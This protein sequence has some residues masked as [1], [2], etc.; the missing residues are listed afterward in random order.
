MKTR[1]Y[2]IVFD[3]SNLSAC[4]NKTVLKEVLTSIPKLIKM[5][6][7]AGPIIV[8]GVKNN[9]GLS[10]FVIID[11]SHISIHTF[12]RY[13]E[14]LIDVFSCKKYSRRAVIDFIRNKLRVKRS[15]IS[16]KTVSWG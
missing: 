12:P 16:V 7:I 15:D 6:I 2:Q 5:K 9:P 4:E 14:I 11:Y 3:V 1:R 10:G 13:K 8:D